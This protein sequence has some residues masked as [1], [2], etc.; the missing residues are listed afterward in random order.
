MART[1]FTTP[2]LYVE[3]PSPRAREVALDLEQANYLVNVLRLGAGAR[4]LL[5]NGRDGEFASALAP[6]S[7]KSASLSSASARGRRNF[8]P[9]STICSRRSSTRA[10]TIWRRRR[11]RWA[12][13]A[14][15]G[16]HPAHPGRARQSRAAARQRARS[17]RAMRRDLAARDRRA[18]AARRRRWRAGRAERLIVFCDEEAPLAKPARRARRASRAPKASASSIGPEGG[19]DE[20]ERAAILAAPRVLR[21]SLGP[22]ILRADTAA[23][24]A[25]ALIQAHDRRLAEVAPKRQVLT[26]GPCSGAGHFAATITL[27]S[28]QR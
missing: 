15:A 7:R 10:S 16:D 9:T 26:F 5:F 12:R 8:R 27:H 23:V 28:G 25:L 24:A 13:G 20:A 14:S 4:V 18:R 2:R 1:D 11:S 6:A 21:L 17:L 3:A 22:R 19:F